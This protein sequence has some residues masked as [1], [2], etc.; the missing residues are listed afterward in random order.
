M[1]KKSAALHRAMYRLLYLA[2]R[3][4]EEIANANRAGKIPNPIHLSIGQ[5]AVS[6]GACVA[7]QPDDIAFGTYRSHALYLAKGGSLRKMLAELSGKATGVAKGKGGSMH[8]G[9]IRAGMVAAS[10]I[11]GTGIANAV[12]YALGLTVQRQPHIV[13]CFFGDGA[14][15]EGAFHE[16]MNFAALK[17]L[18]IIFICENNRYAIRTHQSKRQSVRGIAERAAAYGIHAE[19]IEGNDVLKIYAAVRRAR[20]HIRKSGGPYFFECMTYR[21]REHL[22]P[23]EDFHLGYR[24]RQEAQAWMRRDQVTRIG[25]MLPAPT[26][27]RLE[28]AVEA[29]IRRAFAFAERS[30][31]PRR[32]E[33][34]QDV[35]K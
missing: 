15:E 20:R 7:L 12:G 31:F 14:I 23:G 18:P 33:L 32:E 13:V 5:E 11:V 29:E 22:G 27:Q 16:S 6:V 8:L 26:R 19:R 24:S 2:R 10:A 30:P 1:G 25:A 35:F 28:A 34:W 17:K 21:W 3:T 4:D 9:D